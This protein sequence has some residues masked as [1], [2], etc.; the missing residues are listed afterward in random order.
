MM[1]C[2]SKDL[3]AGNLFKACVPMLLALEPTMRSNWRHLWQVALKASYSS[4]RIKW[5]MV[6]QQ[7]SPCQE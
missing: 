6:I 2:K 4:F 5:R 3:D 7:P 1:V